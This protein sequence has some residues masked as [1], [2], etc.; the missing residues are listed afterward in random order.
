MK[1]EKR[2][3]KTQ[4]GEKIASVI[5]TPEEDYKG[6]VLLQHGLFSDKGG[7]WERRANTFAKN[8]FK[9]IRFD[10]RGYGESDREFH[11]FNLTTGIEDTITILN[12]LEERGEEKFVI[13]GSSFGGLIGIHA[14][15]QDSRVSV[16][17]LRAP[18]TFTDSLFSEMEE[19]VREEGRVSL[20]DEMEGASFDESFFDD[21]EKY[22]AGGAA[23]DFDIP[24]IIFHGDED[25]VVPLEDSEKFYKLLDTGKEFHK[26][27]GEGHVFSLKQDQ[28]VLEMTA[29]WFDQY[30]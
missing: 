3:V 12:H 21:L 26:V 28:R 19:L 15:V 2:F 23:E 6:N 5:H 22:D 9:A 1:V 4:E 14:A 8:G 27:K 7:N 17:G 25:D 29:E 20:E 13:Y 30:L 11:E 10:R 18:A 24:T 16:M